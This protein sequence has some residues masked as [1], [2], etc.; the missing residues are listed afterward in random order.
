MVLYENT[1]KS[2]LAFI[3][4]RKHVSF[5]ELRENIKDFQG[6]RS[7][8][9]NEEEGENILLWGSLSQQSIDN[10]QKLLTEKKIV[11]VPCE[12]MVYVLDGSISRIPV[13]KKRKHYKTPHWLPIYFDAT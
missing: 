12:P 13:A 5:V 1:P 3:K 2:I 11:G 9:I 6:E 7:M 4:K 10:L 8:W